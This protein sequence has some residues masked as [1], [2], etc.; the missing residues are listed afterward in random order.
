MREIDLEAEAI[1]GYE[2]KP[3]R[4]LTTPALPLVDNPLDELE[5]NSGL[6]DE[7]IEQLQAD[8]F[9][10]DACGLESSEVRKIVAR[11]SEPLM[12]S[13]TLGNSRR[14][15]ELDRQLCTIISTIVNRELLPLRAEKIVAKRLD[16]WNMRAPMRKREF[17]RMLAPLRGAFQ[18]ITP[19]IEDRLHSLAVA[20]E[21]FVTGAVIDEA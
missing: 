14:A 9:V 18:I 8:A 16:A 5:V 3:Q 1:S 10:A 2:G 20:M 6:A 7:T 12:L 21:K 19:A 13:K 17:E 11:E 4:P 15:E